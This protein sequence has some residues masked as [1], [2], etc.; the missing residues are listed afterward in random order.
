MLN[1]GP[2]YFA[3]SFSRIADI[4]NVITIMFDARTA[5]RFA[6]IGAAIIHRVAAPFFNAATAR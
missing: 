4:T 5:D 1:A 2:T 3:F 6:I